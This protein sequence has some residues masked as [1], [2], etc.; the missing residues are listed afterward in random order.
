MHKNFKFK[1]N[2]YYCLDIGR[3]S[4]MFKRTNS[5]LLMNSTYGTISLIGKEF[6]NRYLQIKFLILIY[7]LLYITLHETFI[8]EKYNH[9]GKL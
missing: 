3:E 8:G 6:K 4:V 2:L 7:I 1:N 5:K 9:Q